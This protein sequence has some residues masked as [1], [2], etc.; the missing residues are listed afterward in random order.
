MREYVT[1]RI[2][3][4]RYNIET[5][6]LDDLVDFYIDP[7]SIQIEDR[8]HTLSAKVLHPRILNAFKHKCSLPPLDIGR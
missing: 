2:P 3:F 8:R 4:S 7:I 1:A 6:Q 5:G